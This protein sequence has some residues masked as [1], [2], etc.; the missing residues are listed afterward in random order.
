MKPS[1]VSIGAACAAL[2]VALGAFGA[3]ALRGLASEPQLMLWE[4]ATRY[5]FVGA[6]GMLAF[7]LFRTRRELSPLPGYL[8]LAGSAL[9]SASLYA[10]AL[11]APRAFGAV[12]P[13]GGLLLI[14]GFLS[15]AWAAG[16]P[17]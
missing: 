10:L 2:G 3:H 6:L 13:F 4:T 17:R 7:G 12:T 11:G 15:F 1:F 9:F 16:T 5:W 8:L 14:A